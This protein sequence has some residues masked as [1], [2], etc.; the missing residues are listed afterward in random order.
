M[1]RFLNA[2]NGLLPKDRIYTDELRT[3]AWGTD[4]SFYRLTPQVVI[5]AKDEDEVSTIVRTASKFGLPFT[6]RAA[7]TSLS[8][9]SVSDSILI[10]AGKNWEDYSVAADAESITLQPGI[11]GARVNQI[12]KPMGRVFPPDPASI[13]SAMVG[14]IVANNASGMNCGTHANS[15]RMLISAR[16]VLPDGT[17]L[18]TGDAAS[19]EAFRKSHPEFIA[20]IEALRDRVRANQPLADRIRKKYSIKN[21]TGLNLR[22]L[23]A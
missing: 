5:R 23:V 12:L 2:I 14:G 9:Q 3:L 6:F 11:V 19:R 20:K 21:V 17:V 8:G 16:L 18:D 10:V 22:P 1:K 7:G 13:G 4:A 15:D